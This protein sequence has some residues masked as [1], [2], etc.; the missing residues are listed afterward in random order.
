MRGQ[1]LL[2]MRAFGVDAGSRTEL[3]NWW[4]QFPQAKV[5]FLTNHADEHYHV[6]VLPQ[7][8]G[9][10]GRQLL[11]RKLAAWPFSQNMH[12][13]CLLDHVQTLRR[14]ARFLLVACAYS[15]LADW[16]PVLQKQAIRIQGVYTQ[17]LALACWLP[18]CQP[19]LLHRLCIQ[20]RQQ[21]VR[22]SYLQQRLFFS[23][24]I[25]LPADTFSTSEA[26]IGRIVHEISQIRIM[27]VHQGWLSEVDVLQLIWLGQMPTDIQWLKKQLPAACVWA[28]LSEPELARHL[29]VKALPAELDAVDWAAIQVV[30]KGHPLPNLAPEAA[31]LPDSIMRVKRSLHGAGVVMASLMLLAGWFGIQATHYAER[32]MRQ[33]QRQLNVRQ[34]APTD[35]ISQEQLPPLRAL[36][37][38]VHS[39]QSS[40]RLP[41]RALT[42]MQQALVGAS[43]WQVATMTWDFSSEAVAQPVMATPATVWQ[44]TL[45]ITWAKSNQNEQAAMEWPPL[46]RRLRDLPEVERVEVLTP[47]ESAG[48]AQ[49]QGS[50]G[51]AQA[52]DQPPAIKLYL[53]DARPGAS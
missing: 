8:R 7:V 39:L 42:L 35:I 49:R 31:L 33:I 37:Q 11:M 21:Q 47:T 24:L 15:P 51:S 1:R 18:A 23:R 13:A 17:A 50:T 20:Y 43:H 4:Q 3:L 53:R 46:L 6:E 45:A 5:S 32:Q 16:L 12:T 2:A 44:E 38:A 22:I 28:G 27:L 25:L 36:A 34:L 19:G 30:L 14:E 10:A 40:V 26:C 41:A 52:V 29:G 48:G 9:A